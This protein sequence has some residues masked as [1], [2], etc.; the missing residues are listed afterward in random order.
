MSLAMQQKG[1]IRQDPAFLSKV[2]LLLSGAG[3]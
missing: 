3:R 2:G 1:R